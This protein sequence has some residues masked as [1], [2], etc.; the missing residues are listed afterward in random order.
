MSL[1]VLEPG[2]IVFWE[3]S[4]GRWGEIE[5]NARGSVAIDTFLFDADDWD[6]DADLDELP[7]FVRLRKRLEHQHKVKVQRNF[8]LVA[9]VRNSTD[10]TAAV[11]AHVTRRK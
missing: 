5:F 7:Y 9:V 2:E 4:S 1:N 3:F 6:E 8:A 10:K 11:D